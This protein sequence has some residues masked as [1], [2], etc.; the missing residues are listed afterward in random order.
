MPEPEAATAPESPRTVHDRTTAL[1]A[2]ALVCLAL[3]TVALLV[4]N[5]EDE[6]RRAVAVWLAGAAVVG[7]VLPWLYWAPYRVPGFVPYAAVAWLAAAAHGAYWHEW[8]GWAHGVPLGFVA[9]ALACGRY[10][11]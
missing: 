9:G 8:P 4:L 10:S 11:R 3:P 5:V 1:G 6:V 7:A 2:T